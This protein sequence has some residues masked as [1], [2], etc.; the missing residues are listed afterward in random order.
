MSGSCVGLSSSFFRASE[1]NVRQFFDGW[2]WRVGLESCWGFPVSDACWTV[3]LGAPKFNPS[4]AEAVSPW[5]STAWFSLVFLA[6]SSLPVR[7]CHFNTIS[8]LPVRWCEAVALAFLHLSL[9]R[10]KATSGSFSTDGFGWLGLNPAGVSLFRMHV[11]LCPSGPQN[12]DFDAA[13]Q[14]MSGSCVGLSSS[15]FR[16]S[17]SNVR[18]FFDGWFWR[19]GFESCWGFPVSDACWTVPLGAP[20]F[21]PREAE[22]VS[23]WPSTAW[24][25]LVFFSNFAAACQVMSF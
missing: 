25:S 17:E 21:K 5:P 20:K 24:F 22:A 16:A 11:E 4:E 6:I 15:F 10:Q 13:C 14:M 9:G 19:V 8:T 2:F 18:Q 3:P 12:F 7:W 1:S 23:P